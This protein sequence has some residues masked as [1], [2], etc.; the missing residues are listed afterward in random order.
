LSLDGHKLVCNLVSQSR[1]C[2]A[3]IDIEPLE[4]AFRGS[5]ATRIVNE[6][7]GINRGVYHFASKPPG[8][9]EWE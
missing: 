2:N 8:T 5:A 7:K 6:V 3:E 1:W 9:I 4:P